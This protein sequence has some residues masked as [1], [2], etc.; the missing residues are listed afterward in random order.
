MT[1]AVDIAFRGP[2]MLAESI[3]WDA[4]DGALWWVDIRAPSVERWA[5]GSGAHRRWTMPASVGSIVPRARGGMIAG[6][7]TGFHFFDPV[8]GALDPTRVAAL[9][10]RVFPRGGRGRL[11]SLCLA[12]ECEGFDVARPGE[13]ARLRALRAG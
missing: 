1:P 12:M 4:D 2:F 5:P 8:T 3:F 10:S 11:A 13:H 6:L 9:T 7:Q